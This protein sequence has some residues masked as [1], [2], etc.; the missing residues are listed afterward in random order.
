ML[1][2]WKKWRFT[3][4]LA[5]LLC[6]VALNA[7]WPHF[8]GTKLRFYPILCPPKHVEQ[9]QIDAKWI[10]KKWVFWRKSQRVCR[11]LIIVNKSIKEKKNDVLRFY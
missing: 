11:N 2:L 5:Y 8:L 1:T 10:E 6:F 9:D 7:I 4:L 3:F